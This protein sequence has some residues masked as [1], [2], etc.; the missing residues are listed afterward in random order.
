MPCSLVLSMVSGSEVRIT[1]PS[2]SFLF[3]RLEGSLGVFPY[4]E[5]FVFEGNSL[6]VA[7][8]NI[9]P[10][11]RQSIDWFEGLVREQGIMFKVRSSELEM[12][13]S[14]NG[15][16]MEAGGD[17]AV[18]APHVVRAFYALDEVCGLDA[19]TL[20]RF[21]D[22]FQFPDRVRVCLPSEEERACH[23]FLEEV[24]FYKATFLCG[25]RLPVHP[26]VME[27]LSH[28]G[29]SPEQLV[30]N[31]WRIV[32]SLMGIWL[33]ATDGD[34]IRVDELIYLYRLKAFKEH[35]YYELV[36]WEM[37]TRIV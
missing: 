4:L 23:F 2:I 11:L 6:S 37:R 35:R 12:G 31:S 25:L 20:S 3:A 14:S 17:T 34:M 16:P 1:C 18:S 32:V 22:R 8:A 28:F 24:C 10:L 13:L 7:L 30:P 27:L 33:A 9:L 21:K 19:K 29:I 36:S 5:K 26:F 15:S